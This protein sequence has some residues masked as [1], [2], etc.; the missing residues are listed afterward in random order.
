MTLQLMAGLLQDPAAG[1]QGQIIFTAGYTGEIKVFESLGGA[2][3][4]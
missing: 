2:G 3:V 4:Q 1:T